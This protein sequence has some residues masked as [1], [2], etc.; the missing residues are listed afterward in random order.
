MTDG[1][2]FAFMRSGAGAGSVAGVD[3]AA[4]LFMSTAACILEVYGEECVE[5]AANFAQACG[6][7]TV[8][9]EDM[10]ISAKH[11]AHDFFERPD[12][13]A[14]VEAARQRRAQEEADGGSDGDSDGEDAKD[15]EDD[16]YDEEMEAESG[17]DEEDR[18]ATPF[19]PHFAAGD[20]ATRRFHATALERTRTWASWTPDDPVRQMLKS[21]IDFSDSMHLGVACS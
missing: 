18:D 10:A 2:N 1:S 17:S 19:S 9:G 5:V 7:S 16:E 6:R 8:T 4:A 15:D 13:E 3:D 12:L 11:C 21:S 14:R 20:E